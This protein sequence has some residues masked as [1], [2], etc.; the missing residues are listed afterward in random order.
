MKRSTLA[1]TAAGLEAGAAFGWFAVRPWYRHWGATPAE[2]DRPMPLDGRIAAPK[3]NTTMAITI[4]AP[5]EDVWPWLAQIGDPPRAGYYS[6]TWIEKLVGLDIVNAGLLLPEHQSLEVGQT[7]DKNGTMTVLAVEPGRSLALGPPESVDYLKCVWSFELRPFGSSRTRLITR[8]RAEW[9]WKRLVEMT[10][11]L[12]LPM[13]LLIEPG[14]FI[15]E[16]KMLLEIKRLVERA[17]PPISMEMARA[18]MRELAK[19]GAA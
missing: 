10:S 5:P 14:A 15:M 17:R 9:S 7:L 16:R 3:L 13:W 4:D 1:L 8:V 12:T 2:I 6:Y 11:P 19:G 18:R